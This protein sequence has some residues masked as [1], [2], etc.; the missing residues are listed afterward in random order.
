MGEYPDAKVRAQ[1]RILDSGESTGS[2]SPAAMFAAIKRQAQRE[3]LG[4]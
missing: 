1:I 3:L 2:I 4:R